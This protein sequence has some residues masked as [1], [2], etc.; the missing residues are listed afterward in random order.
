MVETIQR[1]LPYITDRETIAEAL[2]A[3]KGNISHAVSS[4][5]PASSS[6]SSRTSSIEREIDSDD[7]VDQTPKKKADRR[8]SRPHPLRMGKSHKKLTVNV[9]DAN[10]IS[11]HP[12]QL[13]AALSRLK[14]DE[15]SDPDETEEEDWQN[16]YKDSE[17][18]SISTSASDTSSASKGQAAHV[19][20]IKLS[21]PKRP[22]D[23]VRSESPT[24][25]G[26]SNAGDYDAD[27]EKTWQP[28][29]I[30]KA[31]GRLISRNERDRLRAEK[32]EKADNAE[33]AEKAAR[34]ASLS[35]TNAKHKKSNQSPPVIDVG[36]K[37]L[38]I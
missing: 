7:E 4:L 19:V 24:S 3:Y 38:R 12:E 35:P 33:N 37:I 30:A 5:M 14:D 31:K 36:I 2:Q 16:A 27:G 22:I 34:R 10:A 6:S 32:A 11:P 21:Q 23:K 15:A 25:S 28:R 13:S 8:P 20:R 1:S 18:T 9:D 17:T 26:Q 29:V